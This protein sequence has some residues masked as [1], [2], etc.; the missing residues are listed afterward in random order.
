MDRRA[1]RAGRFFDTPPDGTY[2]PAAMLHPPVDH[3]IDHAPKV[4]AGQARADAD[5][6][7]GLLGRFMG[8][9]RN[10]LVDTS[11]QVRTAVIAVLGMVFLL[12]FSAVL[13][14]LIGMENS[15]IARGGPGRSAD[16]R[17]V[18]YLVAAGI[19]FVAAV[20]VIEILETHKT[21]G[22]VMKVTSGMKDLEAGTW[23]TSVTLRKND[24]FKEME[25]EFNTLARSLRDRVE[26]DLAAL[27]N[28]EGQVRLAAREVEGG[29]REGALVL[30]RQMAGE[31]QNLRERKRNLL[32][33]ASGTGHGPRI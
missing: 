11:Y 3:E 28:L 33:P 17:S 10:Y 24:N 31:M 4:I 13:F 20:F 7:S 22:V 1:D 30:M 5:P 6:H 9:R 25:T 27:Q 19:I 32:R 8:R 29:N 15:L 18:L 2:I 16:A 23:G 26:D 14:H 21:A 12:V